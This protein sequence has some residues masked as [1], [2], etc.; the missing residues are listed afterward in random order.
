MVT[1]DAGIFNL[2]SNLGG[3]DKVQ[4]PLTAYQPMGTLKALVHGFELEYTK[5]CCL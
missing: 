5:C 3:N 2:E 4:H 1:M